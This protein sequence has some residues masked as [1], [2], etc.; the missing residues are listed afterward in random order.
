VTDDQKPSASETSSTD[1]QPDTKGPAEPSQTGSTKAAAA[2]DKPTDSSAEKPAAQKEPTDKSMDKPA[3][4]PPA[5][6]TPPRKEPAGKNGSNGSPLQML[7]VWLLLIILAAGLVLGGYYLWEQQQSQQAATA[8]L[9]NRLERQLGQWDGQAAQLTRSIQ[10]ELEQQATLRERELANLRRELASTSRRLIELSATSRE[11]WKLAEAEYLLRLAS[12]RLVVERNS[13]TA[14]AM[15]QAADD[16]L[17]EL[18]DS[19]LHPV[20]RALARDISALKMTEPVDR[21][22]LYLRLLALIEQVE[23]LS[24]RG[25]IGEPV[26]GGE[27]VQIALDAEEQPKRWRDRVKAGFAR[28]M[29]KLNQHLRVRTHSASAVDAVLPPDNQI[30]LTRNLL[31]MLEQAQ[32]A[33]LRE[34]EVVYQTSLARAQDWLQKYYSLNPQAAPL[35]A[36]LAQL[37]QEPVTQSLPSIGE[38]LSL[39]KAYIEQRHRLEPD[40]PRA[41]GDA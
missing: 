22:G 41:E 10:R 2:L 12:Q 5:G 4:Q 40:S 13:A 35:Q 27:A 38:A 39:L 34:E 32:S 24:A 23:T 25:P 26:E 18:D 28:L 16:L 11:D 17:R 3:S 1:D 7:L 9:N 19:N 31:L 21:E 30:Y 8:E 33:L 36:E 37:Q 6:K 20:R 29:A 14:L 15:A